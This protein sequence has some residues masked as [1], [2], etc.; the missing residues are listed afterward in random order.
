MTARSRNFITAL[1]GYR[2]VAR[3]LGKPPT[4]VHHWSSAGDGRFPSHLYGA[5]CDLADEAGV[6]RPP[7]D[8]FRFLPLPPVPG[9]GMS[10]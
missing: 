8:L 4:T 9:Q 5:F 6:P 3:R 10:A 2:T 7:L 1:G